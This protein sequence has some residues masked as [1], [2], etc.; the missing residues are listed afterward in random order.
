[1]RTAKREL[2]LTIRD[3]ETNTKI[4][5][6]INLDEI[7]ILYKNHQVNGLTSLLL[8]LNE[9]LN[10]KSKKYFPILIPDNLTTLPPGKKW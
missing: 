2:I 5:A 1:M 4:D 3:I 9:E 10:Q 6:K 7:N 8:A